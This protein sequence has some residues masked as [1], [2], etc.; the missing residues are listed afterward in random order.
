V[1]VPGAMRRQSKARRWGGWR[2]PAGWQPA[3]REWPSSP[4]AQAA[5]LRA[6]TWPKVP[7]PRADKT[8]NSSPED[9][10]ITS[11]TETMRSPSSLSCGLQRRRTAQHG[12]H[13]QRL[14]TQ[15]RVLGRACAKE[16][17]RMRTSS[18]RASKVSSALAAPEG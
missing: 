10:L 11:E 13:A 2:V 9:E 17:S 15:R 18:L 7:L 14:G 3:R 12:R 8:S 4:D 16:R 1:S 6:D 5:A